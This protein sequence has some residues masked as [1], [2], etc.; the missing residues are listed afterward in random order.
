MLLVINNKVKICWF[1]SRN[2]NYPVYPIS[3][4]S[5]CCGSWTINAYSNSDSN[6]AQRSTT[7]EFSLTRCHL[8][9][10]GFCHFIVIGC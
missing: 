8:W 1:V 6:R 5:F 9:Y 3:F 10:E 2:T 4:T 7:C